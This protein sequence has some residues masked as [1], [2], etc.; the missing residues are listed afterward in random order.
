M[1]VALGETDDCPYCACLS[2]GRAV[3]ELREGDDGPEMEKLPELWGI[4]R[5]EAEGA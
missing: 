3:G 2:R 4:E 5:Q 1:P